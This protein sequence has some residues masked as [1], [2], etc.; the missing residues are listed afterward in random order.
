MAEIEWV[1]TEPRRGIA[2]TWDRFM[3][4]GATSQEEI[5]Q[6]IFG[7][8]ISALC[9]VLFWLGDGFDK[10][11]LLIAI[12]I[13]VALDLGGGIV[14]NATAAAKR[15]YHRPARTWWARIGFVAVHL[16][17]VAAVA[18]ATGSGFSFF[19][20]SATFLLA[21]ALIIVTVPLYLQRPVAFGLTA[22]GLL[23]SLLPWFS[24]ESFEWFL[25]LL[26][27]KLLLAHLVREA[28]FTSHQRDVA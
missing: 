6:A 3:G 8:A 4:P 26:W 22:V 11:W 27:V 20:L 7:L 9:V 5:V 21:S 13:I 24:I 19:V 23:L 28:P 14:T 1:P 25:P 18:A 2:G 16:V 12:A 15:W 10:G 17:H